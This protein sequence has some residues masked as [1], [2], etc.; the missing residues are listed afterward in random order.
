M[1]DVDSEPPTPLL[2]VRS[3]ARIAGAACVHLAAMRG[4][5]RTSQVGYSRLARLLNADLRV[6]PGSVQAME[7][8]RRFA[9][10]FVTANNIGKIPRESLARAFAEFLLFSGTM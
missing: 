5:S 7:L 3:A 1:R 2:M 8:P 4:T 10:A 9:A 6:N